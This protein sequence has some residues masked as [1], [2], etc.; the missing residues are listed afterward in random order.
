VTVTN[1]P[2]NA[3]GYFVYVYSDVSDSEISL[4][5]LSSGGENASALIADPTG[6]TFSGTF[7]RAD[8]DQNSNTGNYV[9][10]FA[11][12]SEF[13]LT[14]QSNQ[15]DAHTALNGIQIVAGD[16]IFASGFDE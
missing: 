11:P 9:V 7:V 3:G 6:T 12:S 10:L 4:F 2:P 13:T 1:L 16:R 5:T 14:F 8:P 15:G